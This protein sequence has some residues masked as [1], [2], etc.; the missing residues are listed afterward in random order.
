[1]T[2]EHTCSKCG[3]RFELQPLPRFKD[4]ISGTQVGHVPFATYVYATCPK[5]GKRDWADER[6]F[7]VVLGPRSFYAIVL[8][9]SIAI[10]AL[11]I[12]MGFFFNP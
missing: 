1:M 2:Y 12:Y 5:C 9:I 7:L 4:R 10:V 6:R 3:T 8:A 11:V